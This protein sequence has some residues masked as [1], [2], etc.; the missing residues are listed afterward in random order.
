MENLDKLIR[1]LCTYPDETPWLEFKHNNY[2]P[3]MI[4]QDIS[5][6]A[7]GATL[8]EKNS[9]YFVWGVQDGTHDLVGT[10]KNLQNLKKGNEELENWLRRMLSNNADFEYHTVEMDNVTVGVMIIQCAPSNLF[11]FKK[12]NIFAWAV[13]PRN[14]RIIQH[15][16]LNCGQGS[17]TSILRNSLQCRIRICLLLCVCWTMAYILI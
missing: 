10:D 2:D 1:R 8:D 13:I 17:T 6:L 11:H 15:C 9:A 5:A 14:L 3:E 12:S 4:G 7:N 16:N